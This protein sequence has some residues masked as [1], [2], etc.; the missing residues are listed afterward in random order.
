LLGYMASGLLVQL[1]ERE[2]GPSIVA[3]SR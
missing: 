2:L 3:T 1:Y